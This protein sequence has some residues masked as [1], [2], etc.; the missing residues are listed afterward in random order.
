M[1][2]DK[3]AV[4]T[5]T[6]TW[7]DIPLEVVEQ[8]LQYCDRPSLL[9]LSQ[10][11]HQLNSLTLSQYFASQIIGTLIQL[12]C[13]SIPEIPSPGH[14]TEVSPMRALRTALSL[15]RTIQHIDYH[16]PPHGNY[17]HFFSDLR[18]LTAFIRR[19]PRL[20]SLIINPDLVGSSRVVKERSR[21]DIWNKLLVAAI[22]K[23]CEILALP[24]PGTIGYERPSPELSKDLNALDLQLEPQLCGIFRP[25]PTPNPTIASQGPSLSPRPWFSRMK[26]PLRGVSLDRI[27]LRNSP[28]MFHAILTRHT[29]SITQLSIRN[30]VIW[31]P[32]ELKKTFDSLH[33]P[34][35]ESFVFSNSRLVSPIAFLKFISRHH[36][37]LTL[38]DLEAG[39][40]Q[41]SD[42]VLPVKKWTFWR[43][44]PTFPN[45]R[46]LRMPPDTI[47]WLVPNFRRCPKLR[48]IA[49]QGNLTHKSLN[50]VKS[51]LS[52]L[53]ASPSVARALEVKLVV[54]LGD[55]SVLLELRTAED[56]K[57]H[58]CWPGVRELRLVDTSHS[59]PQLN[60][61]VNWLSTFPS[62]EYLKI[63]VTS[64]IL[65]EKFVRSLAAK[66]PNFKSFRHPHSPL[67][68]GLGQQWKVWDVQDGRISSRTTPIE[69]VSTFDP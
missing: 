44:P 41:N 49:F 48:S 9:A 19:M 3:M 28:Q 42:E 8:I 39:F 15:P 18:D 12:P 5:Q 11:N 6:T 46:E 61:L 55:L 23:G 27:N 13:C 34:A 52:N 47:A 65:R 33:F 20:V 68:A 57:T 45:L 56:G 14:A 29:A 58:A 22:S 50:L 38:L 43:H 16:S 24:E 26:P 7:A 2:F 1:K 69:M 60:A 37:T 32:G 59:L 21:H 4:P 64:Y 25:F 36:T 10:L 53:H 67:H 17:D 63:K 35:L 54:P 62:L 31:E 51:I 30:L 66:C 40:R